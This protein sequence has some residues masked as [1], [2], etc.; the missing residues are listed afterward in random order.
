MNNPFPSHQSRRHFLQMLAGA[1]MLSLASSLSA[2][3]LLTGCNSGSDNRFVDKPSF[4][5]VSFQSMAA[6]NMVNPATMATTS[7]S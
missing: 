6:P 5:N 1:P 2:V 4:N 7:V 3:T